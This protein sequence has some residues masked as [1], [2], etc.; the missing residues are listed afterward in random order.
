MAPLHRTHRLTW[1]RSALPLTVWPSA[2]KWSA[3]PAGGHRRTRRRP[4]SRARR[5]RRRGSRTHC[6]RLSAPAWSD[7]LTGTLPR[8]WR[9]SSWRRPLSRSRT[10]SGTR[11]CGWRRRRSRG[12]R[13]RNRRSNRG[14]RRSARRWCTRRR[15][16]RCGSCSSRR[17]C[18]CRRS[19]RC[20]SR[21]CR[22]SDGRSRFRRNWCSRFRRNRGCRCRCRRRGRSRRFG[23]HRSRRC[24]RSCRCSN[25][26]HP[27]R[28]CC[29]VL[30]F[31]LRLGLCFC[32]CFGVSYSLDMFAHLLRDIRGNGTR[33]RLLFRDAV[34]GQQ[35]NNGFRLD[36]Q[37]AGQLINSDLI[38][39]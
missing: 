1:T 39:V 37:F 10:W 8:A 30:R 34:P 36:L 20:S 28:F 11:S 7:S 38:C 29:R 4:R 27:C 19:R 6:R 9:R 32:R 26:P 17:R 15:F 22:R 24:R 21:W 14:R 12:P 33:V 16:R 31:F 18:A 3:I 5:A 2:R 25:W 35:V 13:S 23:S